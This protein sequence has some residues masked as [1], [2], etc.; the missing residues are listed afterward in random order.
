LDS[1]SGSSGDEGGGGQR[2][3]AVKARRATKIKTEKPV[4]STAQLSRSASRLR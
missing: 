2:R 4:K 1:C 3:R